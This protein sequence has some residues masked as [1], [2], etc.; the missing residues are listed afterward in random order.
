MPHSATPFLSPLGHKQTNKRVRAWA[1]PLSAP[2]MSRATHLRSASSG[3]CGRESLRQ[4]AGAQTAQVREWR[5]P[6]DA[7][8]RGADTGILGDRLNKVGL[9]PPVPRPPHKPL[10]KH[11]PYSGLGE[12]LRRAL[13]AARLNVETTAGVEQGSCRAFEDAARAALA[14][15]G[16]SPPREMGERGA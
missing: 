9:F 10:A 13:A 12:A 7:R 1:P 6:G 14:S 15:G 8:V 3:T 16:A 2:L 4:V 11:L 5:R